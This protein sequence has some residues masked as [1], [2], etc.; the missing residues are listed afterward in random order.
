M[1][2]FQNETNCIKTKEDIDSPWT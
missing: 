2:I 1:Y